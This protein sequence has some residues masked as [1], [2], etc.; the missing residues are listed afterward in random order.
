[1]ILNLHAVM[2][3][4]CANGPGR[5]FAIWFQGCSKRCEGCFNPGTHSF[6]RHLPVAAGDLTAQIVAQKDV[7]GL[8]VSGGEPFEQA[9]ALLEFLKLV[10]E[11]CEIG[12]LPSDFSILVFS[13]LTIEEIRALSHGQEIL[14][15]IDV[16]IDGS[17]DV[18]RPSPA[19]SFVSSVNQN[20]HLLTS[21]Y[22]KDDFCAL[23]EAEVIISGEGTLVCSGVNSI[24][25][26]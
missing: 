22:T 14:A 18:R 4:S 5:R 9:E 15:L 8:S 11:H 12:T 16:L 24:F 10:R 26:C 17:Y 19:G 1:M 20:T 3:V 25:A 23:P 2:P 6:A 13:G 7:E 21:R